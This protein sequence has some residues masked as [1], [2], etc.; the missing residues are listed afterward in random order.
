MSLFAET[1]QETGITEQ[2][3]RD[4]CKSLSQELTA[5]K[6]MD[7][8]SAGRAVRING[9]QR[10]WTA[11]WRS[12]SSASAPSGRLPLGWTGSDPVLLGHLPR[13]NRALH[14]HRYQASTLPADHLGLEAD[15]GTLDQG[16]G[17]SVGRALLYRL[18]QS[19]DTAG[20]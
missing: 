20:E 17:K 13:N 18:A 1:K 4:G 6:K 7:G 5:G 19:L 16:K 10:S 12:W 8:A 9:Y 15:L 2:G 11:G 14:L 3:E